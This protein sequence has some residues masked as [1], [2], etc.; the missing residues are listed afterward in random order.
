MSGKFSR[1]SFLRTT[2]LGSAGLVFG[3]TLGSRAARLERKPNLIVFLPDQQ[4]ADTIACYGG[5]PAFAP[6][7]SK[8]ASQSCVFQQPYVTQPICS[9]SRSCILTGTWPHHNGMTR[10]NLI[11]DKE[12]LCL[13]QLVNDD[14]YQSAYMGKWHLGDELVAQKGFTEWVSIMDW[15]SPHTGHGKKDEMCDYDKFLLSEGLI[16]DDTRRDVFTYNYGAKL[17]LKYSKPKFLETRVSDFL[18]RHRRDPFILF[19]GF[20]EP[21]PPYN[22]P[23]NDTHPL[24]Q[25]DLEPAADDAFGDDM[26]LR[27]RL[28]QEFDQKRFGISQDQHLKVQ[29]KYAGLVTEMDQAIGGI[30]AKLEQLG[31]TD[32]TIVAHTSDHGDMMGAHRMFGKE[33]MFQQA[34]RVP[35]IVRMAGQTRMV[36]I[37]PPVSQIDF[38]P[39]VLDLLGKT[40]HQQCMGKSRLPAM[41]GEAM[42]P[43][44]IFAEWNP[45]S[46]Q[47]V[48]K[49]TT[50]ATP[51]D[52]RRVMAESTRTVITPEGWKLNLRD[53]DKNELYNLKSDP[54]EK[55]NLYGR[56][57]LK[58]VISGLTGR[59]HRWQENSGDTVQV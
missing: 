43:E 29:Q 19:V 41:R 42:P 57:E 40:P 48:R 3:S 17:P 38:A 39:T 1:R 4:R 56:S 21:H 11:L 8:L 50:E 36:S 10:N 12:F 18:D 52:I 23:L 49:H 59:I 55:E 7:L 15:H 28:R 22:G 31:L 20:L 6:N 53:T 26:P 33:V 54:R 30:L 37:A 14:D 2:A 44:T 13:P 46:K 34:I 35:L 27:Y 24:D 51:A 47:R 32:N 5:N 45:S 9:P 58:E 16:P 25:I